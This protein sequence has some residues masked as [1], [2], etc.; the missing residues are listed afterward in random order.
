M[1]PTSRE[2][3]EFLHECVL[4]IDSGS[5]EQKSTRG[6]FF[7]N[8]KMKIIPRKNGQRKAFRKQ[9]IFSQGRMAKTSFIRFQDVELLHLNGCLG[10]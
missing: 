2:G 3:V 4:V 5:R 6:D 10:M 8:L 1:A 7:F 9:A